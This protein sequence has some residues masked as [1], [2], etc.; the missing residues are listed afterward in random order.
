MSYEE[1]LSKI[2]GN[3]N[4]AQVT[5]EN[6]DKRS[7][8]LNTVM[9]KQN[10]KTLKSVNTNLLKCPYTLMKIPTLYM[11]PVHKKVD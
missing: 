11:I 1:P 10:D 4:V 7:I 6:I 3:E 2:W 5:K 8:K 9:S